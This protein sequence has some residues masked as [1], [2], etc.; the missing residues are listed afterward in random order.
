MTVWAFPMG[1]AALGLGRRLLKVATI[2][3]PWVGAG[4]AGVCP[5]SHERS[6]WAAPA[7]AEFAQC[8]PVGLLIS[9]WGGIAGALGLSTGRLLLCW[10]VENWEEQ[11]S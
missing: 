1:A 9:S 10:G 3:V 11:R 6:S 7:P 5:D 2:S 8:Q 4:L